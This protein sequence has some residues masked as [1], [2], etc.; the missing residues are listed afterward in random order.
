VG[1]LKRFGDRHGFFALLFLD[2]VTFSS[3]HEPD[4]CSLPLGVPLVGEGTGPQ[5][6]FGRCKEMAATGGNSFESFWMV[7]PRPALAVRV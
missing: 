1:C 5:K 2:C 7:V 4:A 3:A 6:D